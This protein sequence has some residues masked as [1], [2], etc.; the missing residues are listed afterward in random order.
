MKESHPFLQNNERFK[1]EHENGLKIW[2]L[3]EF[4]GK[5][6]VWSWDC[7]WIWMFSSIILWFFEEWGV[8]MVILWCQIN[9]NKYSLSKIKQPSENPPE[10]RETL[11]IFWFWFLGSEKK[12]DVLIQVRENRTFPS[13]GDW[14]GCDDG[15]ILKASSSSS[16]WRWWWWWWWRTWSNPWAE[17][18]S[19]LLIGE[20][21]SISNS[22]LLVSALFMFAE[23]ES[24]LSDFEPSP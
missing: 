7:S 6:E 3:T 5:M 11:P 4:V 16:V 18:Q 12:K 9:G 14:L 15:S 19:L 8:F 20:S 22:V 17:E 21:D 13:T 10:F 23:P 2:Y 1:Q 24:V